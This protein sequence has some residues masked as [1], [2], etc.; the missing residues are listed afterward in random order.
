[1]WLYVCLR[2]CLQENA[3]P[4]RGA[5]QAL[6]FRYSGTVS[7]RHSCSRVQMALP[8]AQWL[9]NAEDVPLRCT[10]LNWVEAVVFIC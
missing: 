2:R 8:A 9:R 1:M 6:V 3:A 4:N 5:A 7:G 10:S